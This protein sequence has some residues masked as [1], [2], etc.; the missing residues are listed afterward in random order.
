MSQ[1]VANSVASTPSANCHA[2]ASFFCWCCCCLQS[3]C[4]RISIA[5]R[6]SCPHVV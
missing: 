4:P 3:N 6:R 1:A 5:N 2:H